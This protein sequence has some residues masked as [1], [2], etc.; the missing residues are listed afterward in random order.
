[1]ALLTGIAFQGYFINKL[2]CEKCESF[3]FPDSQKLLVY[4][5]KNKTVCTCVFMRNNPN[6]AM[7]AIEKYRKQFFM[8]S[9]KKYFSKIG[10]NAIRD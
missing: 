3:H 7:C 9:K 1:M 6:A 8:K 5:S 10:L 2:F 4:L